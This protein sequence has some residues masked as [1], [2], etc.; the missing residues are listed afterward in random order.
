MYRTCYPK[1][2]HRFRIITLVK[3][4]DDLKEHIL[5]DQDKAGDVAKFNVL[6]QNEV[7]CP[8]ETAQA[9]PVVAVPKKHS[10]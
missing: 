1:K 4:F 10:G 8:V 2:L 9:C 3:G 7:G 5:H 6:S